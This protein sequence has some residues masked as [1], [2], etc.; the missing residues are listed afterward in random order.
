MGQRRRRG[1][2]AR[3][4]A[5]AGGPWWGSD[6][7]EHR[8]GGPAILTGAT[9]VGYGVSWLFADA[10]SVG[11]R[12]RIGDHRL[13]YAAPPPGLRLVDAVAAS[14]AYPPFFAPLELDGAELRL[15]GGT[16][17]PDEPAQTREQL[18]RRIL[19]ADGGVYDNLAVEPVW[20]DHEVVLVSDGGSVFRGRHCGTTVGRLWQLLSIASSGGQTARLRWLRACFSTGLLHGAT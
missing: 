9:E 15:T 11:P 18:R 17:D 20:S 2:G 6:L 10:S 5:R 4:R 19:L 13:G 1:P 16:P 8:R 3:R 14:R 12:G 7:R